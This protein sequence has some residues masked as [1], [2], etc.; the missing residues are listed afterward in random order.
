PLGPLAD[1]AEQYGA[2]LHVDAAFGGGLILSSARHRLAGVERAD[3]LAGGL[4]QVFYQPISCG[5]FLLPDRPRFPH[6]EPHADYLT[7]VTA[8]FPN[9]VDR[10]LATSRRFDALKVW[11]TLHCVPEATLGA[12][13][14]RALELAAR[15]AD[16]IAR[17]PTFELLARPQLS[18]VLFRHTGS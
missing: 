2:W 18:T 1:V 16:Q 4:H 5:G 11:L 7:R 10:S 14:D 9:L 3:S 6:L 12:M 13:V 8:P 15:F 17:D